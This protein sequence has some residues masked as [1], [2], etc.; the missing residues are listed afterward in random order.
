MESILPLEFLEHLQIDHW[1]LL[2]VLAWMLA[3]ALVC[4]MLRW[5]S[6][7]DVKRLRQNAHT[8]AQ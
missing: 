8:C 6:E 4:A 5:E 3:L 7:I 2:F 1:Y